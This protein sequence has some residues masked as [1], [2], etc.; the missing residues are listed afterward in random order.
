MRIAI[1]SEDG[2]SGA[3]RELRRW[4]SEEP[5]LR[6]RIRAHTPGP[7]RP[8]TMGLEADALL[9]LLAPGGVAAVFAGALVAWVQTRRGDQTVTLT[10]PD[11]TTVTVSTTRLKGL[12]AEQNA[13]FVREL[14]AS[15]DTPPTTMSAPVRTGTADDEPPV[16]PRLP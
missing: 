15:L 4:L 1:T 16:P 11:G 3:L 2:D 13:R 6:G 10:R 7:L 12:N 9:A 5:E 8:D 14:A